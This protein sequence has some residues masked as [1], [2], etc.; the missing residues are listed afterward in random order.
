MQA[1]HSHNFHFP[2]SLEYFCFAVSNIKF[3]AEIKQIYNKK[4]AKILWFVYKIAQFK[5]YKRGF[6]S[7]NYADVQPQSACMPAGNF[8]TNLMRW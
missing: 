3:T 2:L 1:A 4:C 5:N 8:S 6:G 7:Q